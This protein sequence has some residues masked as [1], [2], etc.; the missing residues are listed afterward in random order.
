MDHLNE[1]NK[2]T[3]TV[4]KKEQMADLLGKHFKTTVLKMPKELELKE[5]VEI[6]KKMIYEQNGT[7]SK[8]IENLKRSQQEIWELKNK[9]N[10]KYTRVI[11]RQI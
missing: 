8:E 1:K 3:E 11:Q 4:P 10:K 2:S 7:I 6:V 9:M 5:D